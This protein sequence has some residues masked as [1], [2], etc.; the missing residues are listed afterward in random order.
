MAAHLAALSSETPANLAKMNDTVWG[1]L[2]ADSEAE[3]SLESAHKLAVKIYVES[4]SYDAAD[5]RFARFIEPTLP[6]FTAAPMTELLQGIDANQQTYGRGRASLDHPR[7]K[8]AADILGSVRHPISRSR[9]RSNPRGV[10]A[11]SL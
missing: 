2:L 11:P 5:A 10:P 4:R 1:K 3:A 8:S 6:K 9:N 7:V